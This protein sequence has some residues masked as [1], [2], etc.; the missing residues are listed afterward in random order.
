MPNFRKQVTVP[1]SADQ[2]YDLVYDINSYSIFIP[3]CIYSEV[4]EEQNHKSRAM[5]RI[6]KG[7]IGF[8]FTTV[9]TM[10]EGRYISINL[11]NGPFK[12]LK[13]VWV[14]TP[15]G[16]HECCVSLNFEFEFCNKLLGTALNGLFKQLC[17]SMVEAF[18]KEAVV[19]YGLDVKK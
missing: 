2:M 19:R 15:I 10:E 9:N 7:K 14:F 1:Y 12:F 18:R 17:D 6:G 16:A 8:E 13:G 11:E 3:L 4:H 5:M